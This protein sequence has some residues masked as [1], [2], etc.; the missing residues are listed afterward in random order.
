MTN[1]VFW[2]EGL[3]RAL[4]RYVVS[5]KVEHNRMIALLIVDRNGSHGAEQQYFDF[6]PADITRLIRTSVIER[7]LIA[8]SW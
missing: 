5:D 3:F 2:L 7:L 6:I 4:W 1:E 8:S